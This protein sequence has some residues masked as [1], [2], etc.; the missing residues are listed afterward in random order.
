M[1]AASHE[2]QLVGS[3]MWWCGTRET[4]SVPDPRLGQEDD[5]P[6]RPDFQ[7]LSQLRHDHAQGIDIFA[8]VVAPDGVEDFAVGQHPVGMGDK[9]AQQVKLSG[10][11]MEVASAATPPLSCRNQFRP[12]PA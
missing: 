12:T 10:R 2:R 11:E 8:P 4:Q 7:L 5:R 3:S 6:I 9:K 1:P